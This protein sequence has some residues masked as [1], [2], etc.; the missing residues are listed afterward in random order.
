M[1]MAA[2][3]LLVAGVAGATVRARS[4]DSTAGPGTS[5]TDEAAAAAN[6]AG[7]SSSESSEPST[8]SSSPNGD[9]GV[10]TTSSASV[11]G[12]DPTTTVTS[13]VGGPAGTGVTASSAPTTLPRSTSV[14]AATTTS[15][16]T[17][18]VSS[19]PPL[20]PVGTGDPSSPVPSGSVAEIG[21]GWRMQILNVNPNAADI[22]AAANPFNPPPPAGSTL[23][24]VTVAL[25]YFGPDDPKSAFDT[26][27]AGIGASSVELGDCG[28]IPQEL[29]TLGEVF[30]GGVTIG[31]VCFVT[32]PRDASA[33]QLAA[34]G[35]IVHSDTVAFDASKAPGNV[36]AMTSLPGP[37]PG[38]ASTPARLAPKPV[39]SGA[40]IGGGWKLTV[41]GAASDITDSVMATNQFNLPPPSG[42]RYIG[43]PVSYTFGGP[44]TA[45]AYSLTTNAVGSANLGL[46][47]DCGVTPDRVDLSQ[48]LSPGG[49][50]GGTLCFIAPA[51]DP[52][53]TL[54]ATSDF[55][56][57]YVMFATG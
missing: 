48:T 43:V 16:T 21:G 23:T 15:T 25:G 32:T 30:S 55:A 29:D 57:P 6:S 45:S 36:P 33:L 42:F 26:S 13:G 37:Q 18:Q 10:S 49:T 5:L 7:S 44:G 34:T 1:W 56:I 27:I 2:L 47:T 24:L 12:S 35:D 52:R 19:E 46:S 3:V 40:D 54:Y 8:D 14:P 53:L 28:V 20:A 51:A 38:A 17:P 41:T 39:G 9:D 22:V 31:N 50:V 4:H 11:T